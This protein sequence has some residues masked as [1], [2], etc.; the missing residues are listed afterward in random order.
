M[1]TLLVGKVCSPSTIISNEVLEMERILVSYG[2]GMGGA[3][4]EY[5]TS[6]I[7]KEGELLKII[8][9]EGQ[10]LSLNPRFIVE[11]EETK[12]L[13]VKTDTSAHSNYHDET[14]KKS[15]VTQY[16]NMSGYDNLKFVDYTS[17]NSRCF[18]K[19]LEKEEI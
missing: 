6:K 1:K 15:I 19:E 3:N 16:F 18:H 10:K 2:G 9:L 17:D 5:Y 7:K 13:K 11:I 8:T 4:K 14:C 12:V